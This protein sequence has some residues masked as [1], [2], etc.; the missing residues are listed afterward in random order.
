[1][2]DLYQCLANDPTVRDCIRL[3]LQIYLHG[4]LFEPQRPF[5]ECGFSL[6][7]IHFHYNNMRDQFP[8]LTSLYSVA[9]VAYLDVLDTFL[10]VE[11][12]GS[13]SLD[14]G[15]N[16]FHQLY[17]NLRSIIVYNL[18]GLHRGVSPR[19]LLAFLNTCCGVLELELWFGKL[20][21]TFYEQ[22]TELAS[23]QNLRSLRVHESKHFYD[24]LDFGFLKKR[25]RSLRTVHLNIATQLVMFSLLEAIPVN[26]TYIF[27]F[28]VRGQS[29]NQ[30]QISRTDLNAYELLV[31]LYIYRKDAAKE[32][33][34]QTYD[35]LIDLEDALVE[36]QPGSTHHWLHHWLD[37]A[38]QH[39]RELEVTL[40][41]RVSPE[42]AAESDQELGAVGGAAFGG[43]FGG[44][45]VGAPAQT[46]RT[47]LNSPSTSRVATGSLARS[48]SVSTFIGASAASRMAT[49]ERL[50]RSVPVETSNEAADE[51]ADYAAF[52]Q[53]SL[54]ASGGIATGGPSRLA[55][56]G[57][58]TKTATAP[59]SGVASGSLSRA[60]SAKTSAMASVR[61]SATA[62]SN[63]L[64]SLPPVATS[65]SAFA[66]SG[67]TSGSLSRAASVRTSTMP[68]AR[69]SVRASSAASSNDLTRLAPVG[70]SASS[71]FNEEAAYVTPS[72]SRTLAGASSFTTGDL[73]P[74]A[75]VSSSTRTATASDGA[76]GGL[77]RPDPEGASGSVFNEEPAY[78]GPFSTFDRTYA[79][80]VSAG[81]SDDQ[82][83]PTTSA[84]VLP[85]ASASG[86]ATHDP[87]R[88]P[89]RDQFAGPSHDPSRAAPVSTFHEVFDDES[90]YAALAGAYGGLSV[91]PTAS[92]PSG[93]TAKP[94]AKSTKKPLT[95]R[96]GFF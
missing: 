85:Q 54:I 14:N 78:I 16:R 81:A 69:P 4:L 43:A 71:V 19:V 89:S 56:V 75:M 66:E 77:T 67:V 7:L 94:P 88:D 72:T 91:R 47:A 83:R 95:R 65:T 84:S 40:L 52:E 27:D 53:T 60:A 57:T 38:S 20:D 93:L 96:F 86:D 2:A 30:V 37:P 6:N 79:D 62:S 21:A 46:T 49:G 48:A 8:V 50:P 74:A 87:S 42:E 13:V 41:A 55:S 29:F 68:S 35:D 18:K 34:R 17:P 92:A 25:F 76:T 59:G 28:W 23:V 31:K 32:L 90:A 3:G 45:T 64:T 10:R 26:G 15:I 33:Y 1:M 44:A 39:L 70:A 11:D 22:L 51:E 80:V 63:D 36:G 61:S 24:R 9:S 82:S 12:D 73:P 5:S 58:T